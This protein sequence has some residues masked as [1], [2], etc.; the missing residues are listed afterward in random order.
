[1]NPTEKFFTVGFIYPLETFCDSFCN[2]K[3]FVMN[4]IYPIYFFASVAVLITW[5]IQSCSIAPDSKPTVASEADTITTNK[6]PALSTHDLDADGFPDACELQDEADRR[7]FRRW[8]ISIAESQLFKKDPAWRKD[9]HDCAGLIRFAYREAL[10]QHDTS[11]LRSR[12][13][14]VDAAI[15]DVRKYNYPGVP[16]LETKIFRTR[17]GEFS[18]AN[19][20]DTTFAV[21]AL[22][23]KLRSYNTVFLEKSLDNVQPGDL[24]FFLNTGDVQMPQHSMIYLGDRRRP[25]SFDDYV[26]YHTGPRDD[27]AGVLKKVRLAD[28]LKHPDAR[29]HPVPEN[30]Y[31]LGYY[32]WKILD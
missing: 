5:F 7:N 10:K 26:I 8:F 23:A 2:L 31:F 15:A 3:S 13:F 9:D 12:P 6:T 14:L 28:L 24:L 17:D 18:A 4:R 20:S 29:W 32:R 30:R 19:L 22:V 25:P 11:W 1:M 27:D 16:L 21:T